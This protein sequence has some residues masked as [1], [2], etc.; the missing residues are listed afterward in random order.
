V[1]HPEVLRQVLACRDL[2]GVAVLV[3]V[4][5]HGSSL[6][7]DLPQLFGLGGSL[8]VSWYGDCL[9]TRDFPLL[10]DWY[11]RGDLLLDEMVSR[12][13]VLGEV[14]D[15]FGAM[16]RGETLRSVITF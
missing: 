13:I 15:A 16:E 10:V 11:L 14:E 1:G 2:A 5:G 7:V 6:A 3:G 9:P 4:P 8:R 12:Q